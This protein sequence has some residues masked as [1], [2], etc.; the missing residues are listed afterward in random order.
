MKIKKICW[1]IVIVLAAL[2]VVVVV[3]VGFFLGD[4]VKKGVETVGPK[5]AQVPVTVRA[6]DLSLW[7]GSARVKGLVVGNP[8]G[9]K[10]PDAITV[11][12]AS[13]GVDPFS[14]FSKKIHVRSIHLVSPEIT[15]EGGLGGN[16]LSK[17]LDNVRAGSAQ[18]SSSAPAQ[19]AQPARKLQVDDLLVTGAKVHVSLTGL[20]GKQMSLTLP[21]IH[22][23]GLGQ[24][25]GG[26]TAADLTRRTLDAMLSAT[27]KAVARAGTQAGK[28]ALG[29]GKQGEQ[30]ASNSLNK[31]THTIGNLFKK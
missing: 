5:I 29:L 12:A 31:I 17:I 20:G 26:I 14:V 28:A 11:G 9:Y 16:N 15:F 6:V 13:V 8:P 22:L 1:G 2:L 24:D 10:T 3:V 19:P 21:D 4:I 23:T 25:S 18:T 7:R 27:L 30:T